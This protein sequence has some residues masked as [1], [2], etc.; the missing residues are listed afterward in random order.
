M[1]TKR[2]SLTLIATTP[3]AMAGAHDQMVDW[4]RA[5]IE[6]TEEERR[7]LESAREIAERS[8][9]ATGTYKRRLKI[10]EKRIGF[11]R[12]M[13]AALEAG[14]YIVPNFI[15]DAFAI[16]TDAKRPR[17]RSGHRYE[18]F[19]QHPK[20]LAQGE[21]RYVSP[22]PSREL[23][24]VEVDDQERQ[25]AAPKA[26]VIPDFPVMLAKP[27]VMAATKRAMALQLFDEV[28]VSWDYAGAADPMLLPILPDG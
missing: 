16:R 25:R 9:W 28:G 17:G 21:G 22:F 3:H 20:L 2:D 23:Y 4:C 5:K 13:K 12:K 14:Y 7:E 6:E 11:Y 8:N 10:A 27:T 26:F 1:T 15:M 18:R 24:A 19:E